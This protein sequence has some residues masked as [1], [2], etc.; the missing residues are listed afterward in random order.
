MPDTTSGAP[1]GV[2]E[3]DG[4][5]TVRAANPAAGE[6]LDIDPEAVPGE[7]VTAVFPASVEATLPQVLDALAEQPA[8]ED[9]PTAFEEYYPDI[10]RWLSVSLSTTGDGPVLYVDDVSERYRLERRLEQ[11]SDN[12]GRLTMITDLISDILGELVGATTREEIAR[13][14]CERLGET[15]IYEFAWV[16]ERDL[17]GETIQLRASAGATGRTLERIETALSEG[18]DIPERSAIE[19]GTPELVRSLGGDERVPEPVRRAAFAD[20]LQSLLT[21]PLTYGESVY[22]V[23]GVDAATPDAFDTR[24]QAS[25]ATL[26][27]MAGFAVNAVRHRTLLRSDSVVELTVQVGDSGAPLVAAAREHEHTLTVEGLL[28]QGES[29]LCYLDVDRGPSSLVET[30]ADHPGVEDARVV[31]E[32]E[33][34]GSVEARLAEDRTPMGRV[35]TLGGTLRS[36]VFEPTGGELV[37]EFPPEEDIRR[38]ADAITREYDGEVLAKREREREST[39]AS[40]FRTRLGERLTEK[41]E[42]A[43]R[44]AFFADYFESP[45]GSSAEE[46]AGALDITGPTLLHHLRAG[47]RKLLEE[48][49]ETTDPPAFDRG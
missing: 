26:G 34:G 37:V 45:R 38:I 5:G 48:F 31:A 44:T 24:E 4:D 7:S 3:L 17:D 23:V 8:D 32:D 41:Q 35:A 20:G 18:Q 29:M 36:G 11:Q 1:F 46:V 47:Q 43:L 21:I 30:L 15:D 25:F 9:V 40:E 2:L 19:T 39:T 49:F 27:E 33:D 12:V 13:T 10:E 28:E 42:N 16:G 14:I 6:L 22:G